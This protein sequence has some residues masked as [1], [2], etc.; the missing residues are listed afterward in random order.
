MSDNERRQV[1]SD[2][3]IE[4]IAE[5]VVKKAHSAF[6]I[7]EEEHYNQHRRLD[8]LLDSYDKAT[9]TASKI[10]ISLIIVG[11]L[12]LGALATMKGLKVTS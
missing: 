1:L 3:D 11:A 5:A 7:P 12:Y 2:E 10:I 4:K 9:G 8:A 6:F